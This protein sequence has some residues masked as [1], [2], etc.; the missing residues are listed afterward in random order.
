MQR[1][2]RLNQHTSATACHIRN[3]REWHKCHADEHILFQI[4]VAQCLQAFARQAEFTIEIGLKRTVFLA[5]FVKDAPTE[6]LH[7]ALARTYRQ[8]EKV[9]ARKKKD[10]L[11]AFSRWSHNDTHS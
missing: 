5:N 10:A 3:E 2:S 6:I 4:P 7:H 9:D 1:F 8:L 11:P